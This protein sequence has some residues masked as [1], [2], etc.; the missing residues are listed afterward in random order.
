[1]QILGKVSGMGIG[2]IFFVSFFAAVAK[3]IMYVI[4]QDMGE[5]D[6]EKGQKKTT[7]ILTH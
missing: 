5:R 1:M 3:G 6:I 4:K 7:T 2:C